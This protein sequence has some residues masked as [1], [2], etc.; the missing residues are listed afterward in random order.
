M[1]RP[2][3]GQGTSR[4][5]ACSP[6]RLRAVA[7]HSATGCNRGWECLPG[8]HPQIP[9]LSPT[10]SNAKIKIQVQDLRLGLRCWRR[11]GSTH[12][13]DSVLL[14]SLTRWF[15]SEGG[16]ERRTFPLLPTVLNPDFVFTSSSS[17]SPLALCFTTTPHLRCS[18]SYLACDA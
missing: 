2:E 3:S 5:L 7:S 1:F 4:L 11:Q 16:F 17:L 14:I 10:P 18:S 8:R 9:S 13:L 12:D 6:G 15:G